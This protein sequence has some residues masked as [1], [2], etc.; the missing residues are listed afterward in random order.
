MAIDFIPVSRTVPGATQAASLLSLVAAVRSAYEQAVR[1]RDVMN[2]NHDGVDFTQ[3][4]ELYGLPSGKGQIVFNLVNGT[5]GS[6]TGVFQVAD[7]KNMT[8]TIGG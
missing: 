2:H 8:E 5:V 6:M 4:E 1:V 3:I 7:A